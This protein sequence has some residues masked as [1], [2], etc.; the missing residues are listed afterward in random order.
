M[1]EAVSDGRYQLYNTANR[2]SESASHI[3]LYL[4]PGPQNWNQMM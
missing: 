4:P 3:L 2:R 1:W